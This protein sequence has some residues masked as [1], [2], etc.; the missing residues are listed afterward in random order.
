M[1]QSIYDT[2]EQMRQDIKNSKTFNMYF[3]FNP[4]EKKEVRKITKVDLKKM[5]TVKDSFDGLLNNQ[6][7]VS[8]P[9]LV[10]IR[11]T[12]T[13]GVVNVFNPTNLIESILIEPLF[14]P[15]TVQLVPCSNIYQEKGKNNYRQFFS[16]C[17]FISAKS[18]SDFK[19]SS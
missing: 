12:Y 5:L 17:Y 3:N 14:E 2:E 11:S 8:H 15:Q 13:L 6:V 18:N 9:P 1:C 10:F 7:F 16:V 19:N 4:L